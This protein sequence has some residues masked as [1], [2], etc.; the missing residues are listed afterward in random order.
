MYHI[1]PTVNDD[2]EMELLDCIG[3]GNIVVDRAWNFPRGKTN[4][5]HEC[6]PTGTN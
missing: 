6:I 5:I 1:A 3:S 2:S 4:Y